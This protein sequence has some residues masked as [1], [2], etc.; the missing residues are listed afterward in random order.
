MSAPTHTRGDTLEQWVNDFTEAKHAFMGIGQLYEKLFEQ[1]IDVVGKLRTVLEDYDVVS[2][3]QSGERRALVKQIQA[4]HAFEQELI[5]ERDRRVEVARTQLN[6]VQAQVQLRLRVLEQLRGLKAPEQDAQWT[7]VEEN[8]LPFLSVLDTFLT[9]FTLKLELQQAAFYKRIGASFKSSTPAPSTIETRQQWFAQFESVMLAVEAMKH[10]VP[11]V[12]ETYKRLDRAP[13]ASYIPSLS[14]ITDKF[15]SEAREPQFS[16]PRKGFFYKYGFSPA[17]PKRHPETKVAA[18]DFTA[19]DDSDLS[20]RRGDRLT[21]IDRGTSEDPNWWFA[22]LNGKRGL[23]PHNYLT[24]E[25]DDAY[26]VEQNDLGRDQE[27]KGEHPPVDSDHPETTLAAKEATGEG[28]EEAA[29]KR[30]P[31]PHALLTS[32]VAPPV[33]PHAEPTSPRLP[34]RPRAHSGSEDGPGGVLPSPAA[35]SQEPHPAL[36]RRPRKPAE[37]V[38]IPETDHMPSEPE[39]TPSSPA[40]PLQNL[41]L[42]DPLLSAETTASTNDAAEKEPLTSAA[43]DKSIVP[44]VASPETLSPAMASPSPAKS[45]VAESS[46]SSSLPLI[47]EPGTTTTESPEAPSK[48]GSSSPS[49]EQHEYA[50]ETAPPT[51]SESVAKANTN[52]EEDDGLL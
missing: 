7:R 49:L 11:H 17:E 31:R 43:L 1:Q 51:A 37:P 41:K 16:D 14:I 15:K 23:V 13:A 32:P 45:E 21:I 27:E 22:E 4:L 33:I 42:G 44:L 3:E 48:A 34:R 2:S 52:Q 19:T 39:L 36:P 5:T 9:R 10:I 24:S 18:F 47:N 12:S 25:D 8:T 35:P 6:A 38:P 28:D 30:P 46:A 40:A 29:P 26:E 20:F 50:A